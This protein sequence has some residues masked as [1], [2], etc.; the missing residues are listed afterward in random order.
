[1]HF[2]RSLPFA[3]EL[4]SKELK[5]QLLLDVSEKY[6]VGGARFFFFNSIFYFE[7]EKINRFFP[8]KK[9]NRQ[10]LSFLKTGRKKKPKKKELNEWKLFTKNSSEFEK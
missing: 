9:N 5:T 3:H 6:S 2:H 7:G 8:E 4:T 10:K 1:M